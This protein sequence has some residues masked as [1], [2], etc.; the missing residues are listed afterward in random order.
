MHGPVTDQAPGLAANRRTS[1][2][3][4]T[5]VHLELLQVHAAVQA[6]LRADRLGHKD[7]G[8]PL[9]HIATF[10]HCCHP[11]G[12]RNRTVIVVPATVGGENRRVD[13]LGQA[14]VEYRSMASDSYR[15]PRAFSHTPIQKLRGW[16]IINMMPPAWAAS[17]RPLRRPRSRGRW[18]SQIARACRAR[19]ALSAIQ[20][21][22]SRG[23]QTSTQATTASRSISA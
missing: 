3:C 22:T 5:G 19:A 6:A 16:A 7:H 20:W 13:G 8:I 14:K 17:L 11:A 4:R 2:L 15:V 18:A 9:E 23:T 12:K 10:A 21:C 1:I